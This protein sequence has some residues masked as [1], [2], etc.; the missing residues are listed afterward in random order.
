[1]EYMVSNI[2]YMERGDKDIRRL[3]LMYLHAYIFQGLFHRR[4]RHS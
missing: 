2:T 3:E 1:M 4:E